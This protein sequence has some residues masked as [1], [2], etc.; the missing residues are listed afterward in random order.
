MEISPLDGDTG[1]DNAPFIDIKYLASPLI[2]IRGLTSS[3]AKIFINKM[4]NM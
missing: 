1:K 2:L 4:G 3:Y